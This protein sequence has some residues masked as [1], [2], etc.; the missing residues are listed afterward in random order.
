MTVGNSTDLKA[1]SIALPITL[2]TITGLAVLV[3]VLTCLLIHFK[4][5]TTKKDGRHRA[6]SGYSKLDRALQQSMSPSL[7]DEHSF[8]A[9]STSSEPGSRYAHAIMVVK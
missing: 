6:D 2:I 1:L 9:F 7:S 8:T 3:V 4:R 5:Q